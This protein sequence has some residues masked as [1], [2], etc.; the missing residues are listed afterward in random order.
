[1][2]T[3]RTL[4]ALCA[5]I[6]AYPGAIP[7]TWD[8]FDDGADDDQICWGVK[9]IDGID[10]IVMRGSS[11]FTDWKRDFDAWA[12]P[13]H[14]TAI[15]R[16]HPGFLLGMEQVWAEAKGKVGHDIAV[17]GHSLGAARAGILTGLMVR[18]GIAP[19]ARVVFGE[20]KPGFKDFADL[21]LPVPSRS[22][23]AGDDRGH[24]LVTDVPFS[25]PPEQYLHPTSLI[26]V[27]VSPAA[28]DPWGPFRY[29]HMPAYA[30]STPTT[31]IA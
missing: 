29:H 10:V 8:W 16:V 25:F 5:G 4:A 23:C 18:D 20:P 15:G 7:I 21:I 28:A 19:I 24:D 17:T 31:P 22:Y 30:A 14:K 26:S 3:D 27:S 12:D 1:M 13:F 6:Y 2:I 9:R 11:T